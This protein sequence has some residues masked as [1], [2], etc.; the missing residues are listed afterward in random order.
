METLQKEKRTNYFEPLQDNIA[1]E[2][3]AEEII[4]KVELIENGVITEPLSREP[5]SSF[6]TSDKKII[7]DIIQDCYNNLERLSK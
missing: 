5:L 1:E 2:I 7:N 4:T 6:S 3:I